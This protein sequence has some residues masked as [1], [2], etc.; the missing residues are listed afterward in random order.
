MQREKPS[1]TIVPEFICKTDSDKIIDLALKS[2]NKF[3]FEVTEDGHQISTAENTPGNMGWEE[4]PTKLRNGLPYYIPSF[5][6]NP[7]PM[8]DNGFAINYRENTELW[9]LTDKWIMHASEKIKTIFNIEG[10]DLMAAILRRGEIG[11]KMPPHQDGPVLNGKDLVNID[12]SCF[13]YLNDDFEGG[14]IRF[15]ELGFS[16][17][18]IAGSAIFLSNTS[19]KLMVHEVEAITSGQRFSINTFF[20]EV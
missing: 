8:K 13:I 20:R 19:T 2:T 12:F 9:A 18:P 5:S 7:E 4:A 15:E 16:W 6:S 14:S 3:N 1:L 17:K 11:A 10:I